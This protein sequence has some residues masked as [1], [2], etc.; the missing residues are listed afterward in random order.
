[1]GPFIK[2]YLAQSCN[3]CATRHSSQVKS[4]LPCNMLLFCACRKTIPPA[5]MVSMWMFVVKQLSAQLLSLSLCFPLSPLVSLFV[6]LVLAVRVTAWFVINK[7]VALLQAGD[8]QQ[9]VRRLLSAS[10]STTG[11][12]YTPFFK[13]YHVTIHTPVP[14]KRILLPQS[15]AC[16][17]YL[18]NSVNDCHNENLCRRLRGNCV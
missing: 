8:R 1:M 2:Y 4:F 17:I 3:L 6:S 11:K 14:T 16:A 10:S 18:L 9:L 12:S 5:P 15:E 13:S 7:W